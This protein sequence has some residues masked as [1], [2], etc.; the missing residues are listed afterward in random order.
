MCINERTRN[1]F[2]FNKCDGIY[3]TL[4]NNTTLAATNNSRQNLSTLLNTNQL[5]EIGYRT[6]LLN[7]NTHTAEHRQTIN[8]AVDG[9][10]SIAAV[11]PTTRPARH[12]TRTPADTASIRFRAPVELNAH[13]VHGQTPQLVISIRK[14][15]GE[16]LLLEESC[17]RRTSEGVRSL[18]GYKDILRCE[19]VQINNTKLFS[20]T[21]LRSTQQ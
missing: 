5:A 7:Q 10:E 14:D 9:S 11:C 13:M 2:R 21:R 17:E 15:G 20:G 8:A 1:A 19:P 3:T 6:L 18:S 4:A 16:T 12:P